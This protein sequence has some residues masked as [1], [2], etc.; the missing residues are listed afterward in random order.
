MRIRVARRMYDPV[1]AAGEGTY[2]GNL[3]NPISEQRGDLPYRIVF[4]I[5]PLKSGEI[6]SVLVSEEDVDKIKQ[7]REIAIYP[8]GEVITRKVGKNSATP[9]VYYLT[10]EQ[11][12]YIEYKNGN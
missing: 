10:G 12:R 11:A 1:V 3:V 7:L 6:D 9:L 2:Y 4:T 5:N 8:N